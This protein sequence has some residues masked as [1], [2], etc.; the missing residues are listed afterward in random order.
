MMLSMLSHS[1][2]NSLP[3]FF[4]ALDLPA[5]HEPI[6]KMSAEPMIWLVSLPNFKCLSFFLPGEVGE[7]NAELFRVAF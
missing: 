3:F 7:L 4:P 1:F 6:N 5:C 2:L